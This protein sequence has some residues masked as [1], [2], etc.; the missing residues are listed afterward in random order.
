MHA[1]MHVGMHVCVR[2]RVSERDRNTFLATGRT[3]MTI[4][5]S[6]VFVLNHSFFTSPEDFC[7]TTNTNEVLGRT[8]QFGLLDMK[9]LREGP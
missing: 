9:A 1:C 8:R 3:K 7:S 2:Q 5:P 4:C 6:S